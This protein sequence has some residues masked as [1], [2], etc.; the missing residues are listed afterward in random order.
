MGTR[1]G[2][3]VLAGAA[4]RARASG[5]LVGRAARKRRRRPRRSFRGDPLPNPRGTRAAIPLGSRVPRR[6]SKQRSGR[7]RGTAPRGRRALLP[8]GHQPPSAPDRRVRR[9][10]RHLDDLPC[11]RYRRPRRRRNADHHRG[12][13]GQDRSDTPQPR[14]GRTRPPRP[15]APVSWERLKSPPGARMSR[16]T[17][18]PDPQIPKL[19]HGSTTRK[20][21]RCRQAALVDGRTVVAPRGGDGSGGGNRC[22]T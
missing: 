20:R 4:R 11:L 5:V 2:E 22:A 9:L 1:T 7:D 14:R 21:E 13:A 10:T 6:H 3:R 19:R 8:A 18:M 15:G 16:P 12:S 17:C